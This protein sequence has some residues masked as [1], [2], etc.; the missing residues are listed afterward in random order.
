MDK[1]NDRT[2]AVLDR[3]VR[4]PPLSPDASQLSTTAALAMMS[5]GHDVLAP[6]RPTKVETRGNG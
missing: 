6:Y 1:P 3:E 2:F 5:I 4:P